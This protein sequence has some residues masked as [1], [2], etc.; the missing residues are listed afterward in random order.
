[1]EFRDGVV[2]LY[3]LPI[4][5]RSSYDR[6]SSYIEG[7]GKKSRDGSY[8]VFFGKRKNRVKVIYWDKDGYC[9][10]QKRLEAGNFKVELS[11]GLELLN[12]EELENIL[13]GMEMKRIKIRKK[14]SE[15]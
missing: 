13:S 12:K 9:I 4:D 1:M 6:L 15:N 7:V 3:N 11:G 2:M 5:L 8:Y 10:W 14:Y